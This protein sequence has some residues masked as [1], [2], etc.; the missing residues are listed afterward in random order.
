MLLKVNLFFESPAFAE[1]ELTKALKTIKGS[2]SR[3]KMMEATSYVPIRKAISRHFVTNNRILAMIASRRRTST[4]II[5]HALDRYE[6]F[7][8]VVTRPAN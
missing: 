3:E 5:K 6:S 1:I 8:D 4:K 2:C 7:V